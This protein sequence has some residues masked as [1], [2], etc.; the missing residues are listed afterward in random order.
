MESAGGEAGS[1]LFREFHRQQVRDARGRFAGGW[2]FAWQGLESVNDNLI[3]FDKTLHQNIKQAVERL[4][5]E[6]VE[7]A[8][9]NAPWND[10][11]GDARQGLQSAVVWQDEDH[12]TILL[13]HGAEIYYGVWL[14][15]RW[16]GKFAIILPT[17]E[18]F[19]PQI[20]G[21]IASMT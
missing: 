8:K 3:A 5:D 6:M 10:R 14:E 16:G 2:G 1:A 4:A 7:Y 17:I 20:P 19:M 21:R 12:F 11:T 18:H 15:V 9:A 13:G